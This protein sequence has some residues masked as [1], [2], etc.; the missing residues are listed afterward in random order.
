MIPITRESA[1]CT[2]ERRIVQ[3]TEPPSR[4]GDT[5]GHAGCPTARIHIPGPPDGGRGDGSHVDDRC[6]CMD[7]DG[8]A[9]TRNPAVVRRAPDPQRHCRVFRASSSVPTDVAGAVGG[10]GFTPATAVPAAVVSRPN[11]WHRTVAA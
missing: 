4:A 9:G 10:L 11:D 3:Q 2:A 8:A 1:M 7:Y 6:T 5:D